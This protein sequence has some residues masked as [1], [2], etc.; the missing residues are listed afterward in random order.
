MVIPPLWRGLDAYVQL[1]HPPGLQTIVHFG[2]LYCFGA[3]I[4]LYIGYIIECLR[5][6]KSFPSPVF[7]INPTLNDSGVFLLLLSQHLALFCSALYFIISVSRLFWVRLVLAALWASNPLFYTFA[8]FVGN[9][10]LSVILLLL[11]GAVGL[12]IV[13]RPGNVG[14]KR[15][16]LFGVLLWLSILTRHINAVLAGVLPLTFL[17]L[18]GYRLITIP[19]SRSQLLRRWRR[20]RMRQELKKVAVAVVIG[21]VSIALANLSLRGLCRVA[22]TPY[23]STFG[24]TFLMRLQFLA[25][26]SAKERDQLLDQ[27]ARNNSSELL[28]VVIPLLREAFSKPPDQRGMDSLPP[29][30]VHEAFPEGSALDDVLAFYKRVNQLFNGSSLHVFDHTAR[31]FLYHPSKPYV[32]AVRK[33]FMR[34]QQ[35]TVPIMVDYLFLCTIAYFA[36]P[37]FMTQFMWLVTFREQTPTQIVTIL[38]KHR[39]FHLWKDVNHAALLCFWAANLALLMV[40]VHMRKKDVAAVVSYAIALILVGLLMMLANCFLVDFMP[41]YALPMW[42]LTVLSTSILF[43]KTMEYLFSP[44]RASG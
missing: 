43:V 11:V 29:S 1:T 31:A 35:I 23:Y 22:H 15:W 10:A 5:V 32:A 6:G 20:L 16:G 36:H 41:R 40:L 21:I 44:G 9:E 4:P 7:V 12:G 27:L 37:K 24:Y 25:A 28:Q 30:L 17:L 3:R 8:H 2:P 26:L 38:E 14:W 42:E 34:S 18:N 33:D 39:Y 19:L 13:Q